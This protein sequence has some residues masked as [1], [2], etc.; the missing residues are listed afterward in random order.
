MADATLVTIRDR[1]SGRYHKRYR[2]AAGSSLIGYEADNADDAGAYD[3]V[4]IAE[5]EKAD[6]ADLCRRCW[7]SEDDA[8]T[9]PE[10]V[11]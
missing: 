3:E 11:P 4:P 9:W 10:S 5:A 7:P 6:R 1:S 8:S 2:V